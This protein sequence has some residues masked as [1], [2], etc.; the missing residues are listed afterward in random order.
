M[1]VIQCESKVVAWSGITAGPIQEY[2]PP[3]RESR[4]VSYRAEVGTSGPEIAKVTVRI[5]KTWRGE[6]PQTALSI[7]SVEREIVGEFIKERVCGNYQPLAPGSDNYFS[8]SGEQML[9]RYKEQ[10]D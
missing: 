1:P 2:D 8:I 5:D 10:R 6:R 9:G 4:W 7:E 3:G